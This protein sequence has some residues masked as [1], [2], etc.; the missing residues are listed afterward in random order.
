M[1]ITGSL[2]T[3]SL[4]ELFRVI[5][6]GSKSGQLTIQSSSVTARAGTYYLWFQNGRLV[7]VS[8]RADGQGLTNAIESRGWL[9]RRVLQRLTESCPSG[10]ALGVHLNTESVLQVRQLK[11]LFQGQ[12]FQV[13]RLF[14][15]SSGRFNL[16]DQDRK[17]TLPWLEMTGIS[18][19][20][21]E[22][23]LF[24]LRRLKNWESYA[25]QLP[26]RS[27]TLEALVSRPALQ[28]KALELQL[29]VLA[30]G[31]TSLETITRQVNQPLSEVERAAFRLMVAG[32][33]EEVPHSQQQVRLLPARPRPLASVTATTEPKETSKPAE[34]V[35]R[36]LI[37]NLINFLRSW[38]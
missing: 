34:T 11:L 37:Q 17:Q 13:H 15:L 18:L 31:K 16:S 23:A 22:V 36:S 14:E 29:W 7:A 33:V 8:D 25:N 1:S 30:D 5:D 3:F 24:C 12:L 6:T 19:R 35:S 9:R 21:I 38:F 26:H 2:E 32:L 10:K 4:P 20:A 28:L 27:S